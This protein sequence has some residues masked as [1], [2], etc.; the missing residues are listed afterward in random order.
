MS[1]WCGGWLQTPLNSTKLQIN[2]Y[3]TVAWVMSQLKHSW[4]PAV[5]RTHCVGISWGMCIVHTHLEIYMH[6]RTE[7]LILA[8]QFCGWQWC[9]RLEI[10]RT[11]WG[12][13]GLLHDS[14]APAM[15]TV[16]PGRPVAWRLLALPMRLQSS[17]TRRARQKMYKLSR[18]CKPKV[19]KNDEKRF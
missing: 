18:D 5:Y 2:H 4:F 17:L 12:R 15:E 16:L 9:L 14:S 6:S 8:R 19:K 10:V 13:R 1:L 7:V 3:F 11:P